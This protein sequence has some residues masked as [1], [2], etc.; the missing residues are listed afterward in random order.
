VFE[1]FVPRDQEVNASA[2]RGGFFYRFRFLVLGAYYTSSEGFADIG[3]VGNVALA[4]YPAVT[5]QERATLNRELRS[6][7]I[8]V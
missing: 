2:A 7:G 8:K 4:S 5:E 1:G 3:Y 6:L